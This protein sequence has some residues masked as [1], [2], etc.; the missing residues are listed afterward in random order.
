[1]SREPGA[2]SRKKLLAAY[3][4]PLTNKKETQM[5]EKLHRF[6]T[7]I[8]V[9]LAGGIFLGIVLIWLSG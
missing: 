5:E 6:L 3:R 1:V 9:I 2:V 7:D 4:S 8:R